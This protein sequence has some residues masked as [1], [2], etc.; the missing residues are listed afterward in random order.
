[1]I[2][3]LLMKNQTGQKQ[4]SEGKSPS[5]GKQGGGFNKAGK[6]GEILED[7]NGKN[8]KLPRTERKSDA[9]STDFPSVPVEFKEAM[10]RY[11]EQME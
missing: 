3:F 5:A 8:L 1:M 9:G 7:N 11:I 6:S 4:N 2:D 10:E